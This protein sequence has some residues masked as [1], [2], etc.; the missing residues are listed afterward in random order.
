MAAHAYYAKHIIDIIKDLDAATYQGSSLNLRT[1]V[2]ISSARR[3]ERVRPAKS[4]RS[5]T[6]RQPGR[7]RHG[8]PRSLGLAQVAQGAGAPASETL[9]KMFWIRHRP[10]NSCY[11]DRTCGHLRRA[12]LTS[13]PA[14]AGGVC[15]WA[16]RFPSQAA[17]SGLA[18]V[19]STGA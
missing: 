16:I 19:N 4:H 5:A 12:G 14:P 15:S 9:S 17:L 11:L 3:S 7:P 2:A 13:L 10:E 8:D 6:I 18:R 1:G